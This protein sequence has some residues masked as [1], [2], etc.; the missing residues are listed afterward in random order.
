MTQPLVNVDLKKSP[1]LGM[2]LPVKEHLIMCRYHDT[3]V[4]SVGVDGQ[5]TLG[6]GWTA[7]AASKYFVEQV[8]GLLTKLYADAAQS[9]IAEV[10]EATER[11]A[12]RAGE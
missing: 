1:N 6:D 10:P 11:L 5:V 2:P 3:L 4:F 8:A 7:D 12:Q 9:Q